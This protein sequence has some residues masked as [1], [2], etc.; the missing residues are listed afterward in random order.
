MP[1]L[2]PPGGAP[3]KPPMSDAQKSP[4]LRNLPTSSPGQSTELKKPEP[5][6][7]STMAMGSSIPTMPTILPVMASPAE[8]IAP[9]PA[10][11][12]PVKIQTPKPET[13]P[14]KLK[15]PELELPAGFVPEAG[16]GAPSALG[17]KE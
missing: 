13:Q 11:A 16:L 6:K 9:I 4:Q 7:S 3:A 5:M 14:V 12:A 2:V 1:T 8:E 17:S 15:L 10:V